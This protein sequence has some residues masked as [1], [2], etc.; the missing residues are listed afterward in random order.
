MVSG[1]RTRRVAGA[2]STRP[3]RVRV[4]M[5][6][7][8]IPSHARRKH[9]VGAMASE[10][11]VAQRL[12]WK[13]QRMRRKSPR[14]SQHACGPPPPLPIPSPRRPARPKSTRACSAPSVNLALRHAAH[15]SRRDGGGTEPPPLRHTHPAP[16]SSHV[17]PWR[18]PHF[19]HV[20]APGPARQQSAAPAHRSARPPCETRLERVTLPSG[21]RARLL[22]S[23]LRLCRCAPHRRSVGGT[24][25]TQLSAAHRHRSLR[26]SPSTPPHAEPP[27][28]VMRQALPAPEPHSGPSKDVSS[29]RVAPSSPSAASL[30]AKQLRAQTPHG[31]FHYP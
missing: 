6:D 1:A 28:S 26:Q 4:W 18:A 23:S 29:P 24:G 20:R 25:R 31:S 12:G 7:F 11:S 17:R 19:E 13:I 27:Y 3:S 21:C 14:P 2:P 8:W 9:W 30:R 16:P 15:H 22:R 10:R 5:A